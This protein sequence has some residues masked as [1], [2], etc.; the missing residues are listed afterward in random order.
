[1]VLQILFEFQYSWLGKV[2]AKEANS[3]NGHSERI[4]RARHLSVHDFDKS[5]W[6]CQI[7]LSKYFDSPYYIN[8]VLSLKQKEEYRLTFLLQQHLSYKTRKIWIRFYSFIRSG[9]MLSQ[10]KCSA[11]TSFL[12]RLSTF[13][14][15]RVYTVIMSRIKKTFNLSFVIT[16]TLFSYLL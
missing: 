13:W 3:T 4:R 11:I 8:E 15:N 12:V 6:N 14:K 10:H 2:Q 5:I 9:S 7:V 1:M 16:V